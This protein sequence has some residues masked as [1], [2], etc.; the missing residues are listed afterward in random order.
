[1][2]GTDSGEFD[3]NDRRRRTRAASIGTNCIVAK[4]R[5]RNYEG[6]EGCIRAYRHPKIPVGSPLPRVEAPT[7]EEVND[8]I[9][10]HAIDEVGKLNAIDQQMARYT[11]TF[12][13]VLGMMRG[14]DASPVHFAY[15]TQPIL[16]LSPLGLSRAKWSEHRMET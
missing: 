14:I 9:K 2:A 5:E 8:T 6:Y 11:T 13:L 3:Y 12:D 15:P 7:P 16:N 10:T 4:L 1:M